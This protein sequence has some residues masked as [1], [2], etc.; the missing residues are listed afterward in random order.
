MSHR[1]THGHAE[2]VLR[3]HSNRTV[4]NSAA[5][6]A[7]HL[8]AGQRRSTSGP[9]RDDHGRS[10]RPRRTGAR[11]SP[12][13]STDAAAA[14]TTAALD[15]PRRQRAAASSAGDAHALGRRRRLLQHR[16]T[17][18][19]APPRADE[20]GP[21]LQRALN[22]ALPGGSARR[23]RRGDHGAS[24]GTQPGAGLTIRVGGAASDPCRG[25]PGRRRRAGRTGRRLPSWAHEAGVS[26]AQPVDP[27]LVPTWTYADQ[28]TPS[29]G[30]GLWAG[31]R[32]RLRDDRPAARRGAGDPGRAR[33]GL[34]GLAGLGRGGPRR[35]RGAARGAGRAGVT[36]V[37]PGAD[38]LPG[39]G[40]C[41]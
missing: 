33:G 15:G 20:G 34:G 40:R 12:S 14:L 7:P 31:R 26:G 13:R 2:S 41:V 35:L 37:L 4:A 23:S 3:S 21:A 11:S 25:G 30:G 5:Y 24:P 39:P 19:G 27:H 32:A 22:A 28:A 36:C 10:R 29:W 1:Y 9:A 6:L 16:R 38:G 8:A 17:P 18:T